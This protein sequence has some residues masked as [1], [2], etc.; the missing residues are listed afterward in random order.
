MV[1]AQGGLLFMR[2]SEIE[3]GGRV[4]GK[5]EIRHP[6]CYMVS[7]PGVNAARVSLLSHEQYH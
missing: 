1:L 5:S 3:E 6:P 4:R 2:D 7:S